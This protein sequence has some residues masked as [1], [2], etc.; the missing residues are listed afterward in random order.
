[1]DFIR[2]TCARPGLWRAGLQHPARATYPAARFDAAQLE[3]L[4]DDPA[5][6]V[7][8]VAAMEESPAPADAGPALSQA[9]LP[10]PR[11]IVMGVMR[12]LLPEAPEPLQAEMT[13]AVI[14]ALDER[15]SGEAFRPVAEAIF[16][17]YRQKPQATADQAP[18]PETTEPAG[19]TG[20][21]APP[22]PPV[23]EGP[24]APAAGASGPDPEP[25]TQPTRK[26]RPKA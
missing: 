19:E 14:G 21:L 23:D 26:N 13:E 25:P 5:L 7:E 17:R 24:E 22:A 9:E 15:I 1:M 6:K 20:D 4:R 3:R 2:I 10:T 18:Q 16:A 8:H 12:L 11:R